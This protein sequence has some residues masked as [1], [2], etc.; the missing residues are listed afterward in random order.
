[1]V[2]YWPFNGDHK[3]PDGG[4]DASPIGN[5]SFVPDR[6][7]VANKAVYLNPGYFKLSSG[8]YITSTQFSLM[9]WGFLYNTNWIILFMLGNGQQSD[10]VYYGDRNYNIC[11][12]EFTKSQLVFYAIRK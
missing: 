1:L 11:M 8:V 4:A 9:G 6:F 5:I 3:D 7:K 12:G 10:N 2:T